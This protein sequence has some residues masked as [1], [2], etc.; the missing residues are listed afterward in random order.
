M[1]LH[2]QLLHRDSLQLD[3]HLHTIPLP[4]QKLIPDEHGVERGVSLLLLGHVGLHGPPQRP[5]V[6]PQEVL[7]Q[8]DGYMDTNST[9]DL[10]ISINDM[11]LGLMGC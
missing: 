9:P 3:S 6:A 5:C 11:R 2:P 4:G 8:L 1:L 7:G 10:T